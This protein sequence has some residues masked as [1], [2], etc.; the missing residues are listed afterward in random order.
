[1][2]SS[3][4]FTETVLSDT[5]PVR[6]VCSVTKELYGVIKTNVD[7]EASLDRF[8]ARYRAYKEVYGFT[9]AS[10]IY[11]SPAEIEF[12]VAYFESID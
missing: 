6:V 10:D 9:S 2:K 4:P 7:V 12:A 5:Q 8:K 1:M 11:P 3:M